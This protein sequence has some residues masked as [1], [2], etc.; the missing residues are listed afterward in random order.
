MKK[1]FPV[2]IGMLVLGIAA[3]CVLPGYILQESDQVQMK[4]RSLIMLLTTKMMLVIMV[5][6]ANNS[7]P[8]IMVIERFPSMM[9]CFNGE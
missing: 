2:F 7:K 1:I 8:N 3:L 6:T 9:L 4:K 5:R